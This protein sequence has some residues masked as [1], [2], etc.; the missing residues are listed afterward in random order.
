MCW[1]HWWPCVWMNEWISAWPK[2]WICAWVKLAKV[3][4]GF[5]DAP[6]IFQIQIFVLVCLKKAW[7]AV[8][9]R[10]CNMQEKLLKHLSVFFGFML[11]AI[12][13]LKLFSVTAE[14]I[15]FQF[16]IC[17]IHSPPSGRISPWTRAQDFLNFFY[18]REPRFVF[19]MKDF[20]WPDEY[21]RPFDIC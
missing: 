16:A 10:N 15:D 5:V 8:Y 9:W 11:L 12:Q 1:M 3:G 19:L 20:S 7:P 21:M 4:L 6:Q 18:E 14:T 13:L 17:T 2:E